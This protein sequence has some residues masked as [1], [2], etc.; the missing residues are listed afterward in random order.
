MST[1]PNSGSTPG[2][3]TSSTTSHQ[4]TGSQSSALDSA[5]E[6]GRE[7][8][9]KAV[10]TAESAGHQAA[11]AARR[12]AEG[13]KNTVADEVSSFGSSLRKASNDMRDGS[14][15]EQAFGYMAD[16][17]ADISDTVRGKNL[18][19]LMGDLS[20]FGR[21]NP[22]AFLGGAALLGFAGMRLARASARDRYSHPDEH[23]RSAPPPATPV[24]ATPAS[25][26][27][28]AP[29]TGGP[30]QGTAAHQSA[31]ATPQPAAST[32][33]SSNPSTPPGSNKND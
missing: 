7:I 15:Q 12:K 4:G 14:P 2:S 29:A 27:S 16:A 6:A 22:A 18:S 25:A 1:P 8:R 26:G 20:T 13:A 5:R 10:E 21:R 19:E 11:E 32:A 31:A 9:D 28:Y 30:G 3:G 24:G 23:D 17:L 33:A